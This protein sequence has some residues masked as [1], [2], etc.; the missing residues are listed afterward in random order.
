MVLLYTLARI[1]NSTPSQNN[2]I[3]C[4]VPLLAIINVPTGSNVV[5]ISRCL[6]TD[7]NNVL[8]SNVQ[9]QCR[10]QRER[11]SLPSILFLSFVLVM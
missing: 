9:C 10:L 11:T 1:I 3:Y 8:T 5:F 2:I 4:I 7:P 6:V